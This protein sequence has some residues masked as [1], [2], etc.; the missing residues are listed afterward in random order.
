MRAL[1]AAL[2][3]ALAA[4]AAADPLASETVAVKAVA[5]PVPADPAAQAWRDAPAL[6]VPLAPQRSIRLHDRKANEALAAAGPGSA[7][8]RAATDGKDLA[9]LVEW[10]DATESRSGDE[11][12]AFGDAAALELPLSYGA[13][14]RL[15]YVGMGDDEMPVALYLQRAGPAGSVAREAVAKGFGST[16]RADLGGVRVAMSYGQ[17]R[18][19]ALFVRPLAAPG[20]ALEGGLVPFA[21]AV[22]DGAR[23]E[24]GGNK[25]LSGWK[26]LRMPD[27]PVDAAY[28]SELA[29]GYRPEDQ[30]DPARGK[31]LVG[32]MC[33][34]CHVAGD[35]RI[36]RPGVAPDLS[37]IGAIA[38]PAYLR[39]SIV[40]PSLV[41]VPS[42]N[43]A[44]HQDRSAPADARGAWPRAE[45]FVWSRRDAGGKLVSKMPPYASMPEADVKAMVTYLRTLGAPQ[46]GA[47][48]KP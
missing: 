32:S 47:G 31:Q 4:A 37:A 12:D 21:V 33:A 48:R 45:A 36:A 16:A 23:S 30:G 18:W 34:A 1:A 29:W 39:D 28:A 42:P 15:P 46:E 10:P 3:L 41:V 2:L 9:V 20:H 25:A 44:Q 24:R 5:A 8:V 11:V 38:A 7:T 27:R 17:G 19:R 35:R 40:A 26:L 6:S 22:W 43:A 13:G 14:K